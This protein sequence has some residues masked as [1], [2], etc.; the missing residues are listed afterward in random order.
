MAD[1]ANFKTDIEDATTSATT[2]SLNCDI[3]LKD[4]DVRKKALFFA[5]R[6]SVFIIH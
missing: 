5:S 1:A 6:K 3:F 2:D 4:K